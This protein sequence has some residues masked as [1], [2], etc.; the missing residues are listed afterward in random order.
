MGLIPN[1]WIHLL[2]TDTFQKFLSQLFCY[3]NKFTRKV[4]YFQNFFNKEVYL[5]LQSDI[6][7]YNKS[8]KFING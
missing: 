3:N 6:P 8:F 1:H 7:K 2:R 5:T 4:K